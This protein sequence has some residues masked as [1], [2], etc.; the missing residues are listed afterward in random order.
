MYE[1]RALGIRE[2]VLSSVRLRKVHRSNYDLPFLHPQLPHESAALDPLQGRNAIIVKTA[3][4]QT[5][6]TTGYRRYICRSW[7]PTDKEREC[8]K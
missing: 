7:P 1:H 4:D 2:I 6:P 3:T 5:Y 8:K